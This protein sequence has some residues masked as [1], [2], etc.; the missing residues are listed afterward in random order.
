VALARA[1]A[2]EPAILLLDEPFAA[3]DAPTRAPMLPELRQRLHETGAAAVLV[4]HDLGEAFAFGDRIAVMQSGR[5]LA[6]GE[7]AALIAHPPSRAVAELLG[8]ET[9]LPAQVTRRDGNQVS[10]FLRADGPVIQITAPDGAACGVAQ[11]VTFTLPAAAARVLRSGESAPTGWNVVTG[12]I[13]S[14]IALPF[15]TRL[16]VETPVP[17]V[18]LAPWANAHAAWAIGDCATVAFPPDVGHVIGESEES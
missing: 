4:T 18:A 17:I 13:A 3:L 5:I 1:F 7:A 12:R 10:L 15:G 16:T 9:I 11:T 14:A 8:V 6:A 2:T